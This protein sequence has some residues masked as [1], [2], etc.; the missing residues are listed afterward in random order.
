MNINEFENIAK[1]LQQ[2]PAIG[3]R[4][5]V[6]NGMKEELYP[7][8]SKKNVKEITLSQLHLTGDS[9]LSEINIQREIKK[10]LKKEL[11]N[12]ISVLK[13]QQILII[14]DAELIARYNIGLGVFY[15][16]YIGD[17][18]MVVLIIPPED[19]TNIIISRD[20]VEIDGTVTLRYFQNILEDK[21]FIKW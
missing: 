17:R 12:Y 18:T 14:S 13:D 20:Y 7:F 15:D 5:F 4:I 16:Y 21:D 8:F 3:K 11:K 1:Q 10:A 9:I 2:K 19:N 6:W